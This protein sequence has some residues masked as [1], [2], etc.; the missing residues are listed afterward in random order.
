MTD[1]EWAQLR[2]FLDSIGMTY[3]EAME[4]FGKKSQE[5]VLEKERD[6]RQLALPGVAEFNGA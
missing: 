2:N 3:E 4:R 5:Q 6:P 1:R